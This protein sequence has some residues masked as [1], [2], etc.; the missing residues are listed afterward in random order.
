MD[1]NKPRSFSFSCHVREDAHGALVVELDV[2]GVATPR[3]LV[4]TAT[5]DA[6]GHACE[7]IVN[8]VAAVHDEGSRHAS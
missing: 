6:I 8:M 4:S 5:A 1:C 7:S 3:V 2:S